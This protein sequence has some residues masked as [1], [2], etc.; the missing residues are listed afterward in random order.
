[1]KIAIRPYEPK[2]LEAL[3]EIITEFSSPTTVEEMRERMQRI[4]ANPMYATFIAIYECEA[5]GM[6]GVRLHATYTGN[7]LKTQISTIV[8]KE[9]YRRR[10]VAGALVAHIEKWAQEQGSD[11]LYLMSG[12]GDHR[13]AARQFYKNH[14]FD[15]TGYR[16]V[17]KLKGDDEI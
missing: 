6:A 14:G 5:A 16:F 4:E 13:A 3:T 10:G 17:K 9:A 8:T 7:R 11:F 12:K 2:D 15:I 1:M